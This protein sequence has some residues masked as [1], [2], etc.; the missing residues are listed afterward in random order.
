MQQLNE[1]FEPEAP[2]EPLLVPLDPPSLVLLLHARTAIAP[3]PRTPTIHRLP[4]AARPKSPSLLLMATRD[5]T[6]RL[7]MDSP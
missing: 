4:H 7:N 5:A 3:K 2:L 1:P 6:R